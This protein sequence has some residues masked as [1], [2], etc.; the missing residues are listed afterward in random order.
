MFI[1]VTIIGA[2]SVPSAA[3]CTEE[4]PDWNIP[5]SGLESG[6]V[7]GLRLS[8]VPPPNPFC[9]IAAFAKSFSNCI[10]LLKSS[11]I[12]INCATQSSHNALI[13]IPAS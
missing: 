1:F 2:T 12:D 10:I 11:A 4:N 9:Y 8:P 7:T 6:N 3:N 5:T 13:S